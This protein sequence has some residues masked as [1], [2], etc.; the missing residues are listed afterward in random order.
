MA[1]ATT[2]TQPGIRQQSDA[3]LWHSWPEGPSFVGAIDPPSGIDAL[4]EAAGGWDNLRKAIAASGDLSDEILARMRLLLEVPNFEEHAPWIQPMQDW[5]SEKVREFVAWYI[6]TGGRNPAKKDVTI[7]G[8]A[9][10]TS[11]PPVPAIVAG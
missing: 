10:S 3:W 4:C 8:G 1:T 6:Q 11:E 9:A 7:S 2:K 5:V